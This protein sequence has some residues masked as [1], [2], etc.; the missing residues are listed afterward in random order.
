METKD[1]VMP[2]AAEAGRRP[3]GGRGGG[4]GAHQRNSEKAQALASICMRKKQRARYT[5]LSAWG[6]CA[7]HDGMEAPVGLVPEI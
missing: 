2:F 6:K 7:A 5:F 3:R 4:G 1:K